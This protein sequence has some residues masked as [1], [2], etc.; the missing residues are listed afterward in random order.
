MAKLRFGVTVPALPGSIETACLG[1]NA[2]G[3]F[4]DADRN[5]PVKLAAG[6]ALNNYVLGGNGEDLEA[7]CVAI[8]DGGTRNDGL[9]YGSVQRRFL[10]LEATVSG[11]ALA[12]GAQVILAAQSALGT[13]QP[14]PIVKAGT[15][16]IFKWRVKGLLAGTGQ[17]GELILI[18]P[19][20]R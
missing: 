10:D 9:S 8:G 7:V 15:G 18:E 17:V 20:V 2:A 4:V 19:C 12:V 3:K 11:A 6:S 13:A 14:A 1:V 5:K 16:A